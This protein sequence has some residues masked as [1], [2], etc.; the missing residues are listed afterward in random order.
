M[1]RL[2]Q[3]KHQ[4]SRTSWIGKPATI[5]TRACSYRITKERMQGHQV[6]LSGSLMTGAADA[7]STVVMMPPARVSVTCK[8]SVG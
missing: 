1:C 8:H 4:G 3:C 7:K 2:W 6:D 5:C